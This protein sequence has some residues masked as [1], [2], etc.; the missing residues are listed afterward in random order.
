M[1]ERETLYLVCGLL[2]DATVWHKQ[3]EVLGEPFDVRVASFPGF[4]S[5]ADMA[6]SLIEGAPERFSMAGHSMGGRVALEVY[7]AIGERIDR[8]ALL[9]TGIYP[10]H[11]DEPALRQQLIDLA[12][13]RGMKAM[14]EEQW[15]PSILHPDRLDDSEL[16]SDLVRMAQRNSPQQFENQIRAL[17]GRPDMSDLLPGIRC[18]TLIC[19]GRQDAWASAN[20]HVEM[21]RMIGHAELA[22][23]EHCGHMTTMERPQQVNDLL[24]NWMAA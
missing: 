23:I 3:M 6:D 19:C 9:D 5:I 12:Y 7:R 10:A 8:L 17:L 2:S 18:K 22:I 13:S 16:V 4:E 20:Q 1:T 11:P 14:A 21:A 24:L 15:I